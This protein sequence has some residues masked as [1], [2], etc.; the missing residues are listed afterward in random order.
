M[1]RGS[2]L[3]ERLENALEEAWAKAFGPLLV[4]GT[5]SPT[6]PLAFL[7]K[8]LEALGRA[9]VVLGPS[10]D[11]GFYLLGLAHPQPGLLRDISGSTAAVLQETLANVKGLGLT[12]EM[13]PP[14]YDIDSPPDLSRLARELASEPQR[15]PQTAAWLEKR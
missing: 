15:A 14:W 7:E 12:V 4:V 8:A 5:D 9:D 2:H 3:G 10:E 11:G 6:L 1:Q 13:L